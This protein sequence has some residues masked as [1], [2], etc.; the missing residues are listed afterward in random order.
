MYVKKRL[1]N[2]IWIE[3][4]LI[5]DHQLQLLPPIKSTC[6]SSLLYF[7]KQMNQCCYHGPMIEQNHPLHPVPDMQLISYYSEHQSFQIKPETN[8]QE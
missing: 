8:G 4:F 3:I 2:E 5:S 6:V 1:K 7:V